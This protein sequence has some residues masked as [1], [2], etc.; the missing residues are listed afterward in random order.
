M[1]HVEV[2]RMAGD[3]LRVDDTISYMASE[4]R[5]AV[6]HQPGSLGTP[7]YIDPAAGGIEFESFWASHGSLVQSEEA[8]AASV[9]EAARRAGRT[10]T[11]ER[12][13][14]VMFEREVPWR[15]GQGVRVTVVSVE[16][17][18]AEDAV[19]PMSAESSKLSNVENAVAWYGDTAVPLLADTRGFCAALLYAD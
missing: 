2:S 19:A 9:R 11:R 1:L 3:P 4:V 8:I 10:V 15:S 7:L 13:E 16:P 14:V 17:S 5:P 6:E 12:Y 18:R